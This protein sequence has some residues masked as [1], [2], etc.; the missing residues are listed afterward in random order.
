MRQLKISKSITNHKTVS[1][2]R[3]LQE[4]GRVDLI[5][6]EKVDLARKIRRRYLCFRK[7]HKS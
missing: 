7:T 3:Y 5:T 4:I 6:T 2:D 1:L